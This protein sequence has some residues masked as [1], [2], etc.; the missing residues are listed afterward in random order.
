MQHSASDIQN[1]PPALRFKIP[2]LLRHSNTL[3]GRP[4]VSVAFVFPR[5]A[6]KWMNVMF[7]FQLLAFAFPL[8]YATTDQTK[9]FMILSALE[10]VLMEVYMTF[11]QVGGNFISDNG[12]MISR[13][14]FS[15]RPLYWRPVIIIIVSC[16]CSTD[17]GILHTMLLVRLRFPLGRWSCTF[18]HSSYLK[19]SSL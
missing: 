4:H 13:A 6:S 7:V 9:P 1:I 15:R 10:L 18:V 16:W 3:A 12:M 8:S 11:F 19:V 5:A 2:P 17:I 14:F